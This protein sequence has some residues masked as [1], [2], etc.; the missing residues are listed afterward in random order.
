MAQIGREKVKEMREREREMC[1]PIT[2]HCHAII[3]PNT[4]H[5]KNITQ[6]KPD[7]C[8]STPSHFSSFS[9]FNCCLNVVCSLINGVTPTI[10]MLCFVQINS[11]LINVLCVDLVL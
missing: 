9:P 4:G 1:T 8:V 11:V 10:R 7:T 5:E 6:P 2:R 3:L